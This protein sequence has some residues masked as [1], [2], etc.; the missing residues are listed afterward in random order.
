[1]LVQVDRQKEGTEYLV[2]PDVMRLVH[3]E[4]RRDGHGRGDDATERDRAKAATGQ[5]HMRQPA[6]R[7]GHKYAVARLWQ[8]QRQQRK[9]EPEQSIRQAPEQ[10]DPR[11]M[12]PS[13]AW[14]LP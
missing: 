2:L 9:P 4:V 8:G 10:S 14:G 6:L 12:T 5:E 7:P 11:Q 3:Q 13:A 1:M